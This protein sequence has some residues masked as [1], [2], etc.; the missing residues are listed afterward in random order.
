M[1]SEEQNRRLFQSALEDSFQVLGG[2]TVMWNDPSTFFLIV[3][4]AWELLIIFALF[5]SCFTVTSKRR[6]YFVRIMNGASIGRIV[7]KNIFIESVAM[8]AIFL[9]AYILLG[10]IS[11]QILRAE[12]FLFAGALVLASALPYLTIFHFDYKVLTQETRTASRLLSFGYVYKAILM[13]ITILACMMMVSV[14]TEFRQNLKA[15][16]AAREFRDYGIC[17]IHTSQA[18]PVEEYIEQTNYQIESVYRKFYESN[19]AVIMTDYTANSNI[20]YCNENTSD[21]IKGIFSDYTEDLQG[22]DV[23]F[24]IPENTTNVSEIESA[25]ELIIGNYEGKNWDYSMKIVPYQGAREVFCFTT[26]VDA[27]IQVVENPCIIYCSKSPD[28]INSDIRECS[29][30]SVNG[31]ALIMDEAL[32]SYL[33]SQ[34]GIVYEWISVGERFDELYDESVRNCAAF[35]FI[36]IVFGILNIIVSCF[37]IQMHYRLYAKELCIKTILGYTM[38]QKFTSVLE[39]SILTI[40]ASNLLLAVVGYKL[41]VNPLLIGVLSLIIFIFDTLVTVY[42]AY[43]LERNSI[44]SCLKGEAL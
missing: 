42:Y 25:A 41:S 3:Y 14:S 39:Y 23:Y 1:F 16:H 4:A 34:D 35:G 8:I 33:A 18:D 17:K 28:Q 13:C 10:Q 12:H 2:N 6:E 7:F 20:V 44:V 24:L 27:L 19:R 26:D 43:R 9:V 22:A 40:V 37:I 11:T 36:C 21:Y 15:F 29:K 38:M 5:L 32:Q 31:I 30:I